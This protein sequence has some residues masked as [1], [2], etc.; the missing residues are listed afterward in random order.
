MKSTIIYKQCLVYLFFTA[1]LFFGFYINEDLGGG[2]VYD[3]NIHKETIHKLFIDG[4][5]FGF[6]NLRN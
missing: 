6:L 1:T 5:Y 3:Y 2:A 4:L